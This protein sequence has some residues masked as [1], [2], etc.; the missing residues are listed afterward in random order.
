MN[1]KHNSANVAQ[2]IEEHRLSAKN[3]SSK[4]IIIW[5][6]QILKF[7]AVCILQESC[8]NQKVDI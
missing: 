4:N 7:Y 6:L 8:R 5:F 2:I 3:L 1:K